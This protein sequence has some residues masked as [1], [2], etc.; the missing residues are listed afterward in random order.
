NPALGLAGLAPHPDPDATY[1]IDVTLLDSPDHRLVRSGILLAHRV[2]DEVGE[3]YLSAE[4]WQPYLPAEQTEPMSA[5]LP[6]E[7]ADLVRPFRRIGALGPVAALTCERRGSLF[8]DADDRPLADV[9]DA[10]VTVR[11]GGLTTARFREV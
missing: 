1:T 2:H 3:W 10:R 4:G 7:F 6:Q 5:D 9:R 8:R 11:R